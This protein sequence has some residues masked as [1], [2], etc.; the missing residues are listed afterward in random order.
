MN[1][2]TT[3]NKTSLTRSIFCMLNYVFHLY[4]SNF[5][6]LRP[7]QVEVYFYT[8]FHIRAYRFRAGTTLRRRCYARLLCFSPS[9]GPLLTL[10]VNFSSTVYVD[11]GQ[12]PRL[13]C[14]SYSLEIT[15]TNCMRF[16]LWVVVGA[17]QICRKSVCSCM[18]CSVHIGITKFRRK[19]SKYCGKCFLCI[20][21]NWKCYWFTI[22]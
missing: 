20:I 5:E 13:G 2:S 16:K 22:H 21:H 7:L 6:E 10:S 11:N 17:A 12:V 1:T 15:T 9:H 4:I 14:N 18:E 19:I 8:A 3:R